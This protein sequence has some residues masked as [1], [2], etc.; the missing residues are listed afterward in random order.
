MKYNYIT[1]EGCIGAG[2]TTLTEKLAA[3]FNA[4]LVLER[5]VDNPFLAKFY[6]DPEHYAFPLE[7]TFLTDRYQQLKTLLAQRDL[8]TDLVISDYFI[9]KCN[10]FS[11]NN[12]QSDEYNLYLKIYDIISTYLPK[13]ELIIYLHNNIDQLLH[14]IASRGREYEK[15]ISAD[16]LQNIQSAYMNYLQHLKNIPV[17]IVD[18]HKLDFVKN[19]ADY[20][21][22]KSLLYG[23]YPNG[24]TTIIPD[25]P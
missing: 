2:K 13:P 17:L 20:E 19:P 7:M 10:I 14:N 23:D 9:D 11:R 16:Y 4:Q 18:T 8:F 15:D 22:L 12:L 3:E 6:K 25:R 24:I 21:Y 1:I 5:F